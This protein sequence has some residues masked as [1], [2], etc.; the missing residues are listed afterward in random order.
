MKKREELLL[1]D[2]EEK[3]EKKKVRIRKLAELAGVK[4][5]INLCLRF[6]NQ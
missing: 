6:R 2:E 1:K 5:I 4:Y 3:V